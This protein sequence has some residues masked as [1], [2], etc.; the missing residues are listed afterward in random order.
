MKFTLQYNGVLVSNQQRR[1]RVE[2][3]RTIRLAIDPLLRTLWAQNRQLRWIGAH[4]GKLTRLR[5]ASWNGH[6]LKIDPLKGGMD[7][8]LI[9]SPFP[10]LRLGGLTYIM[11]VNQLDRWRCDLSIQLLVPERVG[12]QGDLDNRLKT[13]YDGLQPP[14][15]LDQVGIGGDAPEDGLIFCLVEDDSMIR[16]RNVEVE[17]LLGPIPANIQMKDKR[18]YVSAIIRVT[19]AD[20]NGGP[21]RVAGVP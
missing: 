8:P 2:N 5:S 18:N 20:S 9:R 21:I 4:E 14:Q 12:T 16:N 15:N 17:S 6:A 7:G 11:L 19:L 10:Y 1:Q 3:K 13:L